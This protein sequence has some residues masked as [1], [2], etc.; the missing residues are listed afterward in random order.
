MTS[1]V[2][3]ILG[4]VGLVFYMVAV[5]IGGTNLVAYLP[6]SIGLAAGYGVLVGIVAGVVIAIAG[7]ISRRLSGNRAPGLMAGVIGTCGII[8]K[9]L[10][11]TE[12]TLPF[13]VGI[14]IVGSVVLV[15]V[16]RVIDRV[17]RTLEA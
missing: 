9:L 12:E 13:F 6:I 1:L 5:N 15:L 10:S 4:A 2:G 11:A 17:P 16:A 8:W 14:A 7:T 3:G